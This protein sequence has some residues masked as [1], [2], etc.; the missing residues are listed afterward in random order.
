MGLLT[1]VRLHR[2]FQAL[3]LSWALH[4][5]SDR[6]YGIKSSFGNVCKYKS[7]TFRLA[8]CR[9]NCAALNLFASRQHLRTSLKMDLVLRRSNVHK[10][11][12]TKAGFA[13][14]WPSINPSLQTRTY[15]TEDALELLNSFQTVHTLSRSSV[16]IVYIIAC[17]TL[18]TQHWYQRKYTC[19]IPKLLGWSG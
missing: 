7:V 13:V 8:S 9:R 12:G 18:Q 11:I 5:L 1:L 19:P 6:S 3:H 10:Q 16:N 17:S 15:D 2:N 4:I 14:T